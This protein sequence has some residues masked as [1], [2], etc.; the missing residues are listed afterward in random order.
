MITFDKIVD[1]ARTRNNPSYE[2]LLY[3][4]C[5]F[6]VFMAR[7]KV[8]KDPVKLQEYFKLSESC[9]KEYVGEDNDPGNPKFQEWY[10]AMRGIK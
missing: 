9:P 8:E 3:A 5:A 2:E 1:K 7:L 10:R 4:V 6:D